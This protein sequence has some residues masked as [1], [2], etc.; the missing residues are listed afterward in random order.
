MCSNLLVRHYYLS[1]LC[2][3]SLSL[4]KN[5]YV[6]WST[7]P[8]YSVFE[9]IPKR[10]FLHRKKSSTSYR[11]D[12]LQQQKEV[13]TLAE[14]KFL[15]HFSPASMPTTLIQAPAFS[16]ACAKRGF[17]TGKIS[18]RT[19]HLCLHGNALPLSQR[20]D[21]RPAQFVAATGSIQKKTLKTEILPR[22]KRGF[23][24]LI[25]ADW[26]VA[27]SFYSLLNLLHP[28]WKSLSPSV[29]SSPLACGNLSF[30][31]L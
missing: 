1:C 14:G 28:V 15:F 25:L 30:Y 11:R 4:Y 3:Y 10:R 5:K 17:Y 9:A 12:H 22:Q 20:Q 18:Y 16:D 8:I 27:I 24:M 31:I 29:F 2:L 26:A 19:L 6:S 21:F 7:T 13:S 23:Y